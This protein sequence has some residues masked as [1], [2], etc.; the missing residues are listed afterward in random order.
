MTKRLNPLR[1]WN[2]LMIYAGFWL[3]RLTQKVVVFGRPFALSAEVAAVC[4]LRCPEC[5]VGLGNTIRE[6]KKMDAPLFEQIL[7]KHRRHSFYT[8]LYF[9]GEPFLNR[10]LHHLIGL[11]SHIGYYTSVSTNGHFLDE[12]RCREIIDAGLDRLIVSM[13]GLDQDT[14]AFYRRG[15]T[16]QK[17]A[18]GLATMA[19]VKREEGVRHPL[20]VL[21]FLV[22]RKNEGQIPVL[23][24]FARE[25]GADVVELK[26]MQVYGEEG[27]SA[28]LPGDKR[29]NRY[30][31][32]GK[33]KKKGPCFR[34][35]SHAVYTSDGVLVPC[36]YDKVP[37]HPMGKGTGEDLWFS[38]EMHAFRKKVMTRREDAG[39]CSNCNE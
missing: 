35:W 24:D 2:Y 30:A 39:I 29:F 14:Y 25:Q 31:A 26:S 17:V 15:G 5:M 18:D 7:K 4:N 23:K 33:R 1:I 8:N 19:R 12:E 20:L 28:F 11:A 16:W 32:K 27:V 13:D 9:Q 6:S 38:P 37:Q 36:C 34:L 21:Q 10:D 22:N 3:S